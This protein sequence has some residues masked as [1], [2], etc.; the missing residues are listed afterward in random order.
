MI[1]AHNGAEKPQFAWK[2]I[3]VLRLSCYEKNYSLTTVVLSVVWELD[4]RVSAITMM[5][6]TTAPTTHT[7]G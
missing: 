2:T 4:P 5:S 7:H 1:S 6:N 3:D